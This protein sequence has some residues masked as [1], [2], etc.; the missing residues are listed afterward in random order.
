MGLTKD[1]LTEKLRAIE[2]AFFE[3]VLE[4][5]YGDKKVRY[6]SFDE[7]KRIIDLLKSQLGISQKT[8]KYFANFDK[9]TC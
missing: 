3:G 1:E 7:M 9:G 6:R 5:Q 8:S 2:D 4:V